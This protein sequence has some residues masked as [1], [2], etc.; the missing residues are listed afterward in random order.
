MTE[1]CA[2][3]RFLVKNSFLSVLHAQNTFFVGLAE[4]IEKKK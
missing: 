4:L 3:C 2:F 1:N